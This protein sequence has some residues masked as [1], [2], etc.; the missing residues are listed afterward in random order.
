VHCK[1][2]AACLPCEI[3][4]VVVQPG[5]PGTIALTFVPGKRVSPERRTLDLNALGD[6]GVRLVGRLAAVNDG[7]LQFS[8]SLANQ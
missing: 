7:R 8:G 3:T 5:R 1:A 4:P 2:F 6:S